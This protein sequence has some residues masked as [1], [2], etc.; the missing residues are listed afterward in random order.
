MTSL[1]LL[2]GRTV[3]L[4]NLLMEEIKIKEN[5]LAFLLHT[6]SG[7]FLDIPN[8]SYHYLRGL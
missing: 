7:A 1:S 8:K 5:A 6:S 4:A 2:A 3:Y